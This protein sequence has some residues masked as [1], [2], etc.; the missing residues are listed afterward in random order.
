MPYIAQV[1]EGKRD[2]LHI[3]GN[4]YKNKDGSGVR[5]YIHVVDLSLGQVAALKIYENDEL[6]GRGQHSMFIFII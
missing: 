5:D 3:F 2:K 1:S 6:N 4:V